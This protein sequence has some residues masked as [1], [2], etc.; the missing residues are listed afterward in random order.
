MNDKSRPL[1]DVIEHASLPKNEQ[2]RKDLRAH[3]EKKYGRALSEAELEEIHANM[4]RFMSI[5]HR[6]HVEDENKKLEAAAETSK[7]DKPL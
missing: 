4:T 7:P 1:P 2:Y 3:W 6:W 5:L